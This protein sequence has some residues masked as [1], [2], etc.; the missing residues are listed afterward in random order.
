MPFILIH[1]ELHVLDVE[2]TSL[3]MMMQI[4]IPLI[5]T[6]VIHMSYLKECNIDQIRQRV[7]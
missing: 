4:Q 5:A 2:L 6:S 3:S 1:L 7:I